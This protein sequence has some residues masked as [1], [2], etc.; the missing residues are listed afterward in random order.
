MSSN[1]I[2][3][4]GGGGVDIVIPAGDSIAVYTKDEA[5]VYLKLNYP[6]FPESVTL[7]A[8]VQAGQMVLGPYADG[9][10]VQINANAAEVLYSV[11]LSPEILELKG[12]RLQGD[13]TAL[14]ATG[15]LTAA[16]ILSGIVTSTTAAAVVATVDTGTL[17]DGAG[18]FAVG[19]SFDWSVVNTGPDSFTVTAD[20]DHTVVGDGAVA[21]GT[22]AVFRT[23]KTA[24][25][26][27]V[28]YRIG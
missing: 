21:A 3:P 9:A 22:S 18:D 5:E 8:T 25:G 16:A 4:Q 20:T 14:D 19:D 23:R 15:T 24:V 11:G 13:P 1:V 26:V 2:Y 27:F 7:T 6:Q 12:A 17:M 28:T 10:T